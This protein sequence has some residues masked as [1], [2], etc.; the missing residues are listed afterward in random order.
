M[1][2]N[3]TTTTNTPNS[4]IE[5]NLEFTPNPDTLKYSTNLTLIPS[6]VPANFTDPDKVQNQSELADQ[7]FKFSEVSAVMIGKDFITVTLKSQDNLM[8]LNQSLQS[9]IRD[10]LATGKPPVQMKA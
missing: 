7:L 2:I 5:V 6:G 10:F 3:A 8:E 4:T 9:T 1:A